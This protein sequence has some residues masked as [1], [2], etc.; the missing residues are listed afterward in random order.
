ML[1]RQDE[2]LRGAWCDVSILRGW[3]RSFTSP[4]ASYSLCQ[5][6]C[7]CVPDGQV[8][9]STLR[10]H[11]H[12]ISLAHM[13]LFKQL[14][15]RLKLNANRTSLADYSFINFAISLTGLFCPPLRFP[16]TE[17]TNAIVSLG[18]PQK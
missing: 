8:I 4:R 16:A 5:Y 10:I 14:M 17:P 3:G 6:P 12:T 15:T 11:T 9:M 18:I 1:F 13:L 2:A 7:V